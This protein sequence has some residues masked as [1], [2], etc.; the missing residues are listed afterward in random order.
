MNLHEFYIEYIVNSKSFKRLANILSGDNGLIEMYGMGEIQFILFRLIDKVIELNI[1]AGLNMLEY[2]QRSFDKVFSFFIKE[3]Y[4]PE[5]TYVALC[6]DVRHFRSDLA[7]IDFG[8]GI[9][10]GGREGDTIKQIIGWNDKDLKFF[11]DRLEQGGWS[12]SFVLMIT[13]KTKKEPDNIKLAS[14]LVQAFRE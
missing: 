9:V 12:S 1:D 3:L 14:H 13:E 10:I 7:S 4:E 2:N 11:N 6:P 8:D 5:W